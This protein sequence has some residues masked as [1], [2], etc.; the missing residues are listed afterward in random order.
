MPNI[1]S[2]L[3]TSCIAKDVLELLILLFL[4]S[5]C[6]DCRRV[7][8]QQAH[9]VLDAQL[10]ARGWGEGSASQVPPKACSLA[11]AS[12]IEPVLQVILWCPHACVAHA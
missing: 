9:S 2:W 4:P 3:S 10:R 12:V 7:P 5:M 1:P 11:V 6:C 8:P